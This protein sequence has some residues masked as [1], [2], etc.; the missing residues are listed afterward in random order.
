MTYA[1]RACFTKKI[2]DQPE[3][4]HARLFY[5]HIACETAGHKGVF[6]NP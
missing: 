2:Y 3:N 1:L 4:R 5:E 6:P